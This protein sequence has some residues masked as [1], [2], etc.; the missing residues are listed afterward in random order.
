LVYCVAQFLAINLGNNIK[1][2]HADRI[3]A[4]P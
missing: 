4:G 3:V 1:T 2:W